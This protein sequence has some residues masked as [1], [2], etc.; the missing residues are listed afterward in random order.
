M[1]FNFG[2]KMKTKTI[3]WLENK[4]ISELSKRQQIPTEI[5]RGVE[6]EH[7]FDIA[8]QL[9]I[10]QKEILQEKDQD[11]VTVYKLVA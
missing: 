1:I 9:L 8:L 6:E 7:N 5:I 4:I 2:E 10:S 11:G 3:N